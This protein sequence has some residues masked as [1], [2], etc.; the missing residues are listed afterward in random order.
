MKARFEEAKRRELAA[1]RTT[2]SIPKKVSQRTPIAPA[3]SAW[4]FPSRFRKT[5]T[6]DTAVQKMSGSTRR[7]YNCGLSGHIARV[8]PY[9]K[10]SRRDGEATG[11]PVLVVSVDGRTN[12]RGQRIKDLRQELREAELAEDVDK[13]APAAHNVSPTPESKECTLEPSVIVQMGVNGVLTNALVD[14]G[15]PATIV[16]LKFILQVLTNSKDRQQTSEE[17]RKKTM[18]RFSAPAVALTSCG[19]ERLNIV[20]LIPVVLSQEKRNVDAVVLVQKV[21]SQPPARH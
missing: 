4:K 8:C 9:P 18:E 15:S 12:E 5:D 17:W 13:A 6:P 20:A 2:C 16:S 19:G 14:T 7:C 10:P 11:R 21:S 3:N 1:V